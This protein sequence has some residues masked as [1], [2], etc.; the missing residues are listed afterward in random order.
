[1]D[2]KQETMSVVTFLADLY[3]TELSLEKSLLYLTVK[4]AVCSP[5]FEK[6]T[7]KGKH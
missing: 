1:M 7:G 2:H 4:I 3:L 6:R 5:A